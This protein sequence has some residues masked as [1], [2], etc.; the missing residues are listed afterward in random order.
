M[1]R[2]ILTIILSLIITMPVMAN[3]PIESDVTPDVVSVTKTTNQE[4]PF[5]QP[6]SKRALLKKFLVAMGAVMVSSIA[7]Y[8]GLSIYNRVRN[9]VIKTATTDY[10][11]TLNTPDNLKDA[12]NIYLERTRN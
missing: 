7:L 8:I 2:S 1:K 11:N 4:I 3:T 9:N 6:V 10:T 12:V 5:K